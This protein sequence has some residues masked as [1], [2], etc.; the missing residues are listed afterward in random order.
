MKQAQ[1]ASER[2]VTT[3][4]MDASAWR[5]LLS[6]LSS[7][8]LHEQ[9][10]TAMREMALLGLRVDEVYSSTGNASRLSRVCFPPSLLVFWH[11]P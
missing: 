1:R 5:V 4:Y 6:G 2:W 7:Q 10:A 9:A 3:E 8:G 11:R